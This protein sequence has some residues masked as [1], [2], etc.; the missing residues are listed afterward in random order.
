[1]K[2]LNKNVN[3][4]SLKDVCVWIDQTTREYIEAI[5]MELCD[6]NLEKKI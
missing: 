4:V 1:M 6:D 5:I 3:I 2:M